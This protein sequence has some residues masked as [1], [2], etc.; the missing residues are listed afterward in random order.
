[1]S[2]PKTATESLRMLNEQQ[3]A[4]T[5]GISVALIRR[6]RLK[7]IGCPYV[8]IGRRVVYRLQDVEDFI[9]SCTVGRAQ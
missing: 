7:R 1:M 6:H 3:A 2:A 9:A 4:E 5:L 8:K